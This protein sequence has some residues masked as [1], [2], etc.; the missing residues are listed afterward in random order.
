MLNFQKFY[1]L[2]LENI[3]QKDLDKDTVSGTKEI[4]FNTNRVADAASID[5]A[6]KRMF[7]RQYFA[8]ENFRLRVQAAKE[9][10]LSRK[11]LSVFNRRKQSED[12]ERQE[13][14]AKNEIDQIKSAIVRQG[15]QK[16]LQ[17]IVALSAKQRQ[18]N[19]IMEGYR[20]LEMQELVKITRNYLAKAIK[21]CKATNQLKAAE[22]F[23]ESHNDLNNQEDSFDTRLLLND[24]SKG[25]VASKGL[26][27][28]S[29][30]F[31]KLCTKMLE[32]AKIIN[33][34]SNGSVMD[35]DKMD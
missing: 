1:E 33:D 23:Q 19:P 15:G 17:D 9:K 22:H 10:F 18:N 8:A 28:T 11:D 30:K 20:P 6:A 7:L 29:P 21:F 31:A 13:Q 25:I 12:L 32:N 26:M 35:H 14:L 2:F 27:Q 5:D 24:V 16:M 34:L 4:P 3:N